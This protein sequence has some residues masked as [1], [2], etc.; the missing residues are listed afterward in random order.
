MNEGPT[1]DSIKLGVSLE[2]LVERLL[3]DTEF[4]V[5]NEATEPCVPLQPLS[6]GALQD[7]KTE[8]HSIFTISDIPLQ[9]LS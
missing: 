2:L 3:H 8:V 4:E 7:Y 9:L 5:C 1:R 6:Q